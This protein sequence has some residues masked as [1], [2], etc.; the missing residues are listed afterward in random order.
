M[1]VLKKPIIITI[2]R[3]YGSGGKEIANKLGELLGIP[4]YDRE[5]ISLAAKQSGTDEYA[6]EQLDSGMSSPM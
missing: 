1:S 2:S 5:I 4:V 6:F 3:Q